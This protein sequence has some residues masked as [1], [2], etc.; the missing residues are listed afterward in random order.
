MG[1][2]SLAQYSLHEDKYGRSLPWKGKG[3]GNT[4]LYITLYNVSFLH[5]PQRERAGKCTI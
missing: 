5:P 4:A 3:W 1:S 2:V